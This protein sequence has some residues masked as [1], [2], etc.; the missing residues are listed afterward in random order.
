MFYN[1]G[2]WLEPKL[3]FFLHLYVGSL[4]FKVTI[5]WKNV[6]IVFTIGGI[7]ILWIRNERQ[8]VE[9]GKETNDQ[10]LLA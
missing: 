7:I 9:L 5:T 8:K 10:I 2:T 4:L 6:A 1:L 3:L